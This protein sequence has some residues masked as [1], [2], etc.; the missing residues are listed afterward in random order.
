MPMRDRKGFTVGY[1]LAVV[2]RARQHFDNDHVDRALVRLGRLQILYGGD[3]VTDV[4]SIRSPIDDQDLAAI[5][6][7]GQLP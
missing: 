3:Y 2:R 5:A 6:Q 4:R 1:L 7:C